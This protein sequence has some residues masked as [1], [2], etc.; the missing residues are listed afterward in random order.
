MVRGCWSG[1]R[2]EA[3]AMAY[4]D[5]RSRRSCPANEGSYASIMSLLLSLG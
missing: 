3:S 2:G 5:F 4:R 1:G